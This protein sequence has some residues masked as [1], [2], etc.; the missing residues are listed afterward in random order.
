MYLVLSCLVLSIYL[1]IYLPECRVLPRQDIAAEVSDRGGS[2]PVLRLVWGAAPTARERL[3][4]EDVVQVAQPQ[5]IVVPRRP[6]LVDVGH[7]EA[8]A[9]VVVARGLLVVVK[10]RLRRL[11]SISWIRL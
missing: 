8:E 7:V 1:S 4:V 2:G 3:V 5:P 9:E 10:G 11:K 6:H